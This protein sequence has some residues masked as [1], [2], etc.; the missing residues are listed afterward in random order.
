MIYFTS[1]THFEDTRIKTPFS[2]TEDNLMLR[3][4]NNVFE[5]NDLI[6]KS[7]NNRVKEEDI[8]IHLGDVSYTKSGVKWLDKI[9][10]KNRILIQGNHDD[11]KIEELKPYFKNIYQDYILK[12]NND[13]FYLNHYPLKCLET[14][15][16]SICGHVHGQWRLQKLNHGILNVGVDCFNYNPISIEEVIFIK[17]AMNKYYDENIFPYTYQPNKMDSLEENPNSQ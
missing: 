6:I 13:S 10:C 9:N 16:F 15:L 8:L 5:M 7:I 11:D 4:F 14:E 17:N 12:Y 2:K 3:W 1:D